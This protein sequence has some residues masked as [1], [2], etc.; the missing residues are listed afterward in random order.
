MDTPDIFT[1]FK[2]RRRVCARCTTKLKARSLAPTCARCHNKTLKDTDVC[3]VCIQMAHVFQHVPR[4][5]FSVLEYNDDVAQL[6]H[7]YKFVNDAAL[8]EVIAALIEFDFNPYDIVI[9]IPIS[10]R[11]LKERTYNQTSL[12]LDALGV[13]YHDVLYTTKTTRQSEL[14]K[15]ERLMTTGTFS[16]KEDAHH[17]LSDKKILLV[18]DVYTTG[19]T[20]HQALQLIKNHTSEHIDVLT[21]SR[22]LI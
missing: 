21:F 14:T 10:K 20:V 3:D 2:K 13:R 8:C 6:M 16:L 11:R 18:D 19:I 7:R 17:I 4:R 9:P 15:R 5:I 12:V 1:L 22:S